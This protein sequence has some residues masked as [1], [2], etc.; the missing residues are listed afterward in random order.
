[1]SGW[2][3][4]AVVGSA[5]IGGVM[6]NKAA[7]TQADAANRASDLQAQSASEATALQKEMWQRQLADQAPW[8]AAG[9]NALTKMQGFAAPSNFNF[10]TADFNANKDPG[11]A[12]RLSEGLKGLDRQA[13]ARGGLISGAALKAAVGYG[14]EAGSQEFGN[15]YNRALTTYNANQDAQNTQYNRLAALAG[16]GQT[17]NTQIASAGQNYANNAG[18]NMMSSGVNAGNAAMAAGQARASSY[19]GWGNAIGTGLTQ[20]AQ[21]RNPSNPWT[22]LTAQ[23]NSVQLSD[24]TFFGA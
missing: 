22:P 2:V 3:A 12:F 14:Q 8:Q 17:A 15:S 6:G 4:G 7:D 16:V 13:A 18:N 21:M 19:Q 10:G 9:T 5:V 24:G 11:Y 23:S 1:M 20:F